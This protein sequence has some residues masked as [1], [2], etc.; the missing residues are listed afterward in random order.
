M[1]KFL[2]LVLS[3]LILST[4]TQ[5]AFLD[6]HSSH[7][8]QEAILYLQEHNIV[9][10]YEDSTFRPW[11]SVNRAEFLKIIIEGSNIQV[12]VS[13]NTPFNDVNHSTWYSPYLEKAYIE[14]WVDGYSD[15]SFRP[16]QTI[17]KVEAL[18]ILGEVQN[19]D[20]PNNVSS[21]PFKDT[22]LNAWYL[23]YVD[24]AK[25][26]GFLEENGDNFGPSKNMTRANI[27]EVIYRSVT[28]DVNA[29]EEETPEEEEEIIEEEPEVVEE[30]EEEEP[31][32]VEEKPEDNNQDLNFKPVS[33]KLIPHSFYEGF[34]LADHLPNTFYENEIYIIEGEAKSS[35]TKKATIILDGTSNSEYRTFTGDVTNKQFAIAVHLREPGNYNLGI[36]TGEN[37]SSNA[38]PISILPNLPSP[39]FNNS[40]PRE[41]TDTEVYFQDDQTWTSFDANNS[42]I[43]RITFSQNG[44]EVE[45]I[46]RQGK[47]QIPVNYKDFARFNEGKVELRVDSAVL[48]AEMPLNISSSF[49]E[50]DIIDFQATQHAFS[51]ID[52]EQ[53]DF[54]P[55]ETRSGT[56]KFSINGQT[57]GDTKLSAYV[58]KPDGFVDNFELETNASTVSYFGSKIL[59]E[60][61]DFSFEYDPNSEGVYILE[62][63]DKEG[64]PIVNHPVYIG[65]KIPLLPDFFDINEREFYNENFNLGNLRDDMID[66]IN[67]DREDHG[68]DPVHLSSELNE[69]AQNHAQDMIDNDYFSH[70]NLDGESPEDRRRDAGII[71]SVG[72]N[73]AQDTDLEFAQAGLMRSAAHRNN[74][75]DPFWTRVG[76]G[77]VE[78]DGHLR[79]GQEFSSDPL[80]NNDLEIFTT[81]LLETINTLRADNNRDNLTLDNNLNSAAA[82]LNNKAIDE[83][84]SI[85]NDLFQ[86]ALEDN[87]IVGAS[88]AL[89]R[90]FNAWPEILESIMKEEAL[91][92]QSKWDHIGINIQLDEFG[93]I[94]TLVVVNNS[95]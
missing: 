17:N 86:Q 27:S 51:D 13:P 92:V 28:L 83:N 94:H 82:F 22:P 4:T 72:E 50:G 46:N 71:T 90:I 59:T 43:N 95:N 14:G 23:A 3:F 20:L 10:G 68:L 66:L 54:K 49:I 64:K 24:Y 2:S 45:Y 12:G 77:I 1:K 73:I 11:K 9:N 53:I 47:E 75:L 57:K 25:E 30:E 31:A 21:R 89:G 56:N 65:S 44:R 67:E 16:N 70:Y 5:A 84:A 63:N 26:M 60:G 62:I 87:N 88:Q 15:G 40:P 8:N 74:I 85:T 33:V 19:W 35:S 52:E 79:V 93:E 7:K 48:K 6:V 81:E 91:L 69:I 58:I 18:K 36:I 29:P 76:I 34:V 42:S 32:V 80:S 38:A 78:N 39:S 55:P 37:G 61:K 41:A